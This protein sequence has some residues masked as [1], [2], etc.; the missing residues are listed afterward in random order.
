[1]DILAL[2]TASLTTDG[3]KTFIMLH[4]AELQTIVENCEKFNCLQANERIVCINIPRLEMW[5]LKAS[6]ECMCAF[7]LI[8]VD[9]MIDHTFA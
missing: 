7:K 5:W 6:Y 8:K 9:D 3:S 2:L 1:M 4:G